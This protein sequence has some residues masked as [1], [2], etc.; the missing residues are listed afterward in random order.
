MCVCVSLKSLFTCNSRN[1][2]KTLYSKLSAEYKLVFIEIENNCL[3]AQNCKYNY[4]RNTCD[5]LFS[6]IKFYFQELNFMFKILKYFFQY[7]NLIFILHK[8]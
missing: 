5:I 8:I 3:L 1:I 6:N 2:F 7:R 4:F